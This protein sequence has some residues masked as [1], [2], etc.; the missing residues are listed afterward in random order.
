MLGSY[1]AGKLPVVV[2]KLRTCVSRRNWRSDASE[3]N[4][5]LLCDVLATD[6]APLTESFALLFK[7]DG[8]LSGSQE[9]F[10]AVAEE[11]KQCRNVG[12]DNGQVENLRFEILN[13]SPG[14]QIKTNEEAAIA[15]APH[16]SPD[17]HYFVLSNIETLIVGCESTDKN[18][19]LKVIYEDLKRGAGQL[20]K[21]RPS[22][23]ACQLEEIDDEDWNK[24]RGE[25]VWQL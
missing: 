18:R 25:V 8:R 1:G 19:V 6:L 5:Y 21:I 24:L 9:L 15:L 7:S 17:A 22:M 3:G 23:L 2:S 11:I 10:H 20:F 16:W 13:L 4:F 14:F 12:R